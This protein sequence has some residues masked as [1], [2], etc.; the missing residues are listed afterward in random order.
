MCIDYTEQT[1][2]EAKPQDFTTANSILNLGPDLCITPQAM[3]FSVRVY[4]VNGI[5]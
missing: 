3:C 2:L 5:Q 1:Q 4:R